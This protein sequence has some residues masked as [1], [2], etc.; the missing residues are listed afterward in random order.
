MEIV[1]SIANKLANHNF[2]VVGW[3]KISRYRFNKPHHSGKSEKKERSNFQP[4]IQ[5]YK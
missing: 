5:S 4:T 2:I 1:D 3:I